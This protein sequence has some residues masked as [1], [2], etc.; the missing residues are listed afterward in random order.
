MVSP[1]SDWFPLRQL[2]A[3]VMYTTPNLSASFWD[4]SAAS[5]KF[6]HSPLKPISNGH[7]SNINRY[8]T[9]I[10]QTYDG[11]PVRERPG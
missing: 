6:R 11:A 5:R 1:L 8:Q 3:A 9:V 2:L 7:F 10:S 4:S